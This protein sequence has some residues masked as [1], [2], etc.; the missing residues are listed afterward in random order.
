MSRQVPSTRKVV[1]REGDI[2]KSSIKSR[3]WEHRLLRDCAG[4][5]KSKYKFKYKYS[6]KGK[7]Q[8]QIQNTRIDGTLSSEPLTFARLLYMTR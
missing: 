7:L 5:Y 3:I 4:K 8:L 6:H 2:G 1:G